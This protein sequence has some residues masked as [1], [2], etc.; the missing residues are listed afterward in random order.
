N[1]TGVISGTLPTVTSDTPYV[2]TV[3]ATDAGGL[4]VEQNFTITV[5]DVVVAPVNQAPTVV[6]AIG[7]VSQDEG[8][9]LNINVTGKFNDPE[10]GTLLYSGTNFPTGITINNTTGVISGT[11]PT[12][13]SDT[14]YV[15]TVRATDAGGLYVEQNFTITVK[16]VEASDTQAPTLSSL[17][18]TNY[19]GHT[20]TASVPLSVNGSDNIGITGYYVQVVP[21]YGAS[22]PSAPSAAA[23]GWQPS[24]S[25]ATIS[26]QGHNVVYVWA[27]DAAGNVSNSVSQ[28]IYFDN[29]APIASVTYSAAPGATV[30]SVTLTVTLGAVGGG[31][32]TETQSTPGNAPSGWTNGSGWG[33]YTKTVYSN[34]NVTY[35]FSDSAGNTVQ[36]TPDVSQ[37]NIDNTPATASST[38]PMSVSAGTPLSGNITF[39]ESVMVEV[40]SGG[41]AFGVTD[42]WAFV[43]NLN[44]NTTAPTETGNITLSLRLTD[45]VGNEST[46][47][48]TV[49]VTPSGEP[50]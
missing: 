16:N 47:N 4:Y 27:K 34:Q 42:Q 9:A 3:R 21:G 7:N 22:A 46:V 37:F 26:T 29:I 33:E 25:S 32:P 31:G 40:L 36:I 14:P 43:N 1:T 44:V 10:G 38:L 20:N 12:V 50:D 15:V 48:Y 6:S 41:S 11:L 23:G 2:V 49:G 28:S 13:T 35:T 18:L 8:T 30:Q 39:S 5:K 17:S 24:I 45:R 19:N